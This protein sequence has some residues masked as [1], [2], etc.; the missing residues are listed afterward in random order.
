MSAGLL[1]AIA[2]KGSMRNLSKDIGATPDAMNAWLNRGVNVPLEYAIEIERVTKGEVTWQ[3]VAPHLAHFAKRWSGYF[4][5]GQEFSLHTVNVALS[6]ITHTC[7][8]PELTQSL[9]DLVDDIKHHGLKHPICVDSDNSLVFGEKRLHSYE[10]LNKKTIPAWR[11][12]LFDLIN[13][14]YNK[15]EL[16]HTFVLSERVAISLAIESALG[17]RQGQRTDRLLRQNVV[18]VIGR[19]DDFI[20]NLLKFG[21]RQTYKHAKKIF[22]FGSDELIDAVDQGQVAI[23]AA[24]LLLQ[25]PFAKQKEILARSHTEITAHVHRLRCQSYS[26]NDTQL[27]EEES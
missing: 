23:S 11:L 8:I 5:T 10:L 24:V 27:M 7:R 15:D 12:S 14:K 6:R 4:I 16:H 19:T 20:A 9:A 13:E 3:K 18:E 25:L 1:R 26:C 17:N 21:N 2:I 22:Q